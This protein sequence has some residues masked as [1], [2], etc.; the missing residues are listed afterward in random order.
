[1]EKKRLLIKDLTTTCEGIAT[2]DD[3]VVFIDGALPQEEVEVEILSKKKNYSSARLLKILSPSEF[4][5]TPPCK[6][7]GHCGG[8]GLQHAGKSLQL[9]WKTKRVIDALTRIGK[10]SNLVVEECKSTE[11]DYGYRNKITTP[12]LE[13]DGCKKIG[14]FKKRS[15]DI[16]SIDSCLLHIP[17][18][19]VIYGEVRKILLGSELSFY[20]E[21]KR[22][23]DFQHLVIR[24]SGLE[25]KVLIGIIGLVKPTKALKDVAKLI[26]AIKGVKGVVYGKKEKAANSIYPDFLEALEGDDEIIEELLGVKVSVS[27]LSFFQVN[28]PLAAMLYKTAYELADVKEGE[29]VLDAYSGIGLFAIYLAKQGAKVTAIE[30]FP[31]A[32]DDARRNALENGVKVHFIEGMVEEKVSELRGFETI[33]INPP[34]KGVHHDVID[35]LSKIGPK[36]I[37]YTSCD[38]ATLARDV[39]LLGLKGYT[40][41]KAIPFDMFP[42]TI[43]VETVALLMKND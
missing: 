22:T 35:A 27:L 14:F 30:S 9:K 23:G 15:H 29:K 4:R 31:E 3:G 16:V 18:A 8:C 39:A 43:H 37:V 12:L 28:K 19:D 2:S 26:F 42:Q 7:F 24:S 40:L 13:V 36:K 17:M 38:P 20:N 41:I 34:R 10:V 11:E 1:M 33:F 5:V 6:Y 21:E 25:N 32:V